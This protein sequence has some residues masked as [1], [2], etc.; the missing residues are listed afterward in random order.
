MNRIAMNQLPNKLMEINQR[1]IDVRKNRK[2]AQAE[3]TSLKSAEMEG[4]KQD[5]L[6]K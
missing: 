5:E 2:P 6:S 3:S 1:E 4:T